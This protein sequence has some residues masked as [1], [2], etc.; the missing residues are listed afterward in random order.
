MNAL[1]D[2]TANHA[3]LVNDRSEHSL[4]PSALDTPAG[5]HIVLTGSRTACLEYIDRVWRPGPR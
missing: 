4:W 3:V 1:D 2:A 5:W